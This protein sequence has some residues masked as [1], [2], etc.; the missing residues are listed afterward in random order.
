MELRCKRKRSPNKDVQLLGL[1]GM[2]IA[3][4]WGNNL[5]QQSFFIKKQIY[6]L[7]SHYPTLI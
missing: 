4:P 7:P 1:D 3:A 2:A 6:R 5:F